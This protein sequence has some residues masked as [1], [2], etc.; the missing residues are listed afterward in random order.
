MK[1]MEVETLRPGSLVT[2]RHWVN[3]T[4]V[5]ET[6]GECGLMENGVRIPKKLAHIFDGVS[7]RKVVH[8]D[9]KALYLEG[10]GTT[11][12]PLTSVLF[13]N[14][15][16]SEVPIDPKQVEGHGGVKD[17]WIEFS[18]PTRRWRTANDPATLENFAGTGIAPITIDTEGLGAAISNFSE[19][20]NEL[21]QTITTFIIEATDHLI[22]PTNGTDTATTEPTQ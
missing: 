22:F 7:K 12:F 18:A 15:L 11:R 3:L 13:G 4:T 16:A 9:S 2:P 6:D 10:C 17:G 20:V 21:G 14:S 1:T 5:Y 8:I 19:E